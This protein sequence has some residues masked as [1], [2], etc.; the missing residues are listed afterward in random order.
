MEYHLSGHMSHRCMYTVL[1]LI[2]F[3]DQILK[4]NYK[5]YQSPVLDFCPCVSFMS[6]CNANIYKTKLML[7]FDFIMISNDGIA[8][9]YLYPV[10]T[11]FLTYLIQISA[12]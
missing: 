6:C 2:H 11:V 7:A 8:G 9:P 10:Y 4:M 5:I 12:R 1:F 3:C